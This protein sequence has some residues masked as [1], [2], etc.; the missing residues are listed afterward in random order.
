MHQ[1][2]EKNKEIGLFLNRLELT[3]FSKFFTEKFSVGSVEEDE[4]DGGHGAISGSHHCHYVVEN[5]QSRTAIENMNCVNYHL[6]ITAF[7]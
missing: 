6:Q 4:K 1:M 2:F 3:Q 5:L 7:S